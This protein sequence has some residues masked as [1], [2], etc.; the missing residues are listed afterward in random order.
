[1]V[2]AALLPSSS[3]L[4]YASTLHGKDKG[5]GLG[6]MALVLYLLRAKVDGAQSSRCADLMDGGRWRCTTKSQPTYQAWSSNA[7][8]R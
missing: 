3:R 4:L 8:I 6:G 1:M 5:P 2:R 7:S